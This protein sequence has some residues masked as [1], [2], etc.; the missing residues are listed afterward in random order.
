MVFNV[1]NGVRV[2]SPEVLVNEPERLE[3]VDY[4]IVI[5]ASFDSTNL[6]NENSE[7]TS[8]SADS[9]AVIPMVMVNDT[10]YLYTGFENTD[11]HHDVM[12]G[13]ITSYYTVFSTEKIPS[14]LLWKYLRWYSFTK[15]AIIIFDIVLGQLS[16]FKFYCQIMSMDFIFYRFIY[17]LYDAIFTV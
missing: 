9:G 13:K 15:D 6:G 2:F 11:A 12:N 17:F 8:H 4:A 7:H 10:L 16:N 5:R 3:N 1:G 14:L